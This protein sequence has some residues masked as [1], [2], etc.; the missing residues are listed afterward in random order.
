M[1]SPF[2]AGSLCDIWSFNN[3]LFE[4]NSILI[5]AL[6]ALEK[7]FVTF[8]INTNFF[9]PKKLKGKLTILNFILFGSTNTIIGHNF[10]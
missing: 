4:R 7:Y 8:L 9:S 1:N 5:T 6:F 10:S 3:N 2:A